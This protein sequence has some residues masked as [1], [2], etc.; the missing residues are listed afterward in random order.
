MHVY[1][2]A[3]VI[4]NQSHEMKPESI[5]Q[6]LMLFSSCITFAINITDGCGLS[7]EAHCQ[8]RAR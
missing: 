2:S 5:K 7:N 1:V 4:K 8:K 3:Q 6:V